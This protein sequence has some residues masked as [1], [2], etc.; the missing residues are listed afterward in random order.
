MDYPCI[1]INLSKVKKNIK[2][3][4]D[5]CAQSGISVV[6]VTKC[7]LGDEKI[8]E[9]FKSNG[10]GI[11][12]DSRLDNLKKLNKKFG[13]RQKLLLLRTPMI[14]EIEEMAGFCYAS[15]NTQKKTV[16]EISRVCLS[17]GI[18]HNI[19]IMVETDDRREGLLPREVLSFAEHVIYNCPAVN[20]W[21]IGTNA[22]CISK[23]KPKTASVGI[24]LK[25]KAQIEK[26]FSIHIPIVSGGNS[27]VMGLVENGQMPAGINQVRIGEA[28][29]LGHETSDYR[30]IDGACRDAF[31]LDA[32]II[33]IKQ[34]NEKSYK[35]IAGLGLQDVRFKNLQL[36]TDG[37]GFADQSSDHTVFLADR[38]INF[39]VGDIISFQPDYFGLLSC[40]T[41]PF[42]K[43]LYLE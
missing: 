38:D 43:K 11:I 15:M 22:R 27:S 23:R 32:E 5:R 3:I 13:P 29:L 18:T 40:M 1:K 36:L 30:P 12:G 31:I 8:A 19:M 14:S 17:R 35:V 16:S 34:K 41:S 42:V 39:E 25:L 9:A 24:L 20:I 28:I 6:G 21:G 37:L 4:N 7:V 33:E 10:I 26:D 2:L